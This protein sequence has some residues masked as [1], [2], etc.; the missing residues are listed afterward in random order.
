M[1]YLSQYHPELYSQIKPT[2]ILGF[3]P[4]GAFR[5]SMRFAHDHEPLD[6]P[7]AEELLADYAYWSDPVKAVVFMLVPI[8][9]VAILAAIATFFYAVFFVIGKQ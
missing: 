5:A 2:R 1:P 3:Y 9:V 6:D 4:N 8:F 7:V